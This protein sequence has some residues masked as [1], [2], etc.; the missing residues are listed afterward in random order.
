MTIKLLFAPE[1]GKILGAQVVGEEGV[2]KRID[3]L[4]MA[5]QAGLTV[6]DLEESELAYAPQFGSAKDPVNM[7]GFVAAGLLRREH[8]QSSFED[9]EKL[10]GEGALLVDVRTPEEF[11]AGAVPGAVNVPV[12]ELRDR[13]GELPADRKLLL[14]CGVGLRGYVGTRLLRHLGRDASNLSGG[15]RTYRMVEASK[16]G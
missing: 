11:A 8:P 2:D 9:L 15:Y 13:L 4:A 14:Y 1:D 5:I 3:V 16:P 6:Y 12:D 7:V 10:T